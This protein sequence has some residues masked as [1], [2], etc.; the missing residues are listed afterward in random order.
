MCKRNVRKLYSEFCP[1]GEGC[2]TSGGSEVPAG[3]DE[4]GEPPPVST[5]CCTVWVARAG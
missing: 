4:A 1:D 5:V 3:G 2:A